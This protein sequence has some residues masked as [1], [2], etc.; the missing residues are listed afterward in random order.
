MEELERYLEATYSN[1]YQPSII[2]NTTET[3]TDL[4]MPTI[5]PDTGTKLPM[6]YGKMIYLKNKNI[7]EAIHKKLRN[8]GVYKTDM[9]NIYNAIMGKKNY[10]LQENLASYDIFQAFTCA[11]EVDRKSVV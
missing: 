2:N 9:H 8:K 5:I 7:D 4:D 1:I 3:F 11:S 10:Q 6:T